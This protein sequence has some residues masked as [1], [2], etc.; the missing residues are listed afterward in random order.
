MCENKNDTIFRFIGEPEASTGLGTCRTINHWH[1]CVLTFLLNRKC[2]LTL[3]HQRC[4]VHAEIAGSYAL[5]F[6][7]YSAPRVGVFLCGREVV[8][9]HA[10]NNMYYKM[11]HVCKSFHK[12]LVRMLEG[13]VSFKIFD[14]AIRWICIFPVSKSCK[15]PPKA[16]FVSFSAASR[17]AC[18]A[19]WLQ[20]ATS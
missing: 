8:K 9:V 15:G 12:W 4:E 6:T 1:I 18:Y 11:M 10:V 13:F 7:S 5:S 19:C 3:R 17:T 20:H 14:L 16:G 2:E